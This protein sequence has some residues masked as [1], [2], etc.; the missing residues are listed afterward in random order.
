MPG[1]ETIDPD[2]VVGLKT[3]RRFVESYLVGLNA[4][5][6]RELLWRGY[7]TDLRAT[8]AAQFWD[9]RGGDAPLPDIAPIADWAASGLGDNAPGAAQGEPFV[10]LVRSEL[11]RRYPNATVYAARAVMDGSQ[12]VPSAEP[13]DEVLPSFRASLPP[14]ILLFGFALDADA[15]VGSDTDP[16][17][18]VV[19]QEHAGEPRFGL[20]AGAAPAGAGWL[21]ATAS[22]P[23][24]LPGG[25]LVWGR[26]AAHVAGLLR[27]RPVRLA[28]HASRLVA[29][30]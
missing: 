12:R 28:I 20:D 25:D 17:W 13:A 9:A 27:R 2:R 30:P 10:L 11:L 15:V 3:N 14:D 23:A 6:G 1:L 22:E 18:F 24:G 26:N 16:G 19:I 7:P 29:A 4:E 21:D 8:Y 5:L